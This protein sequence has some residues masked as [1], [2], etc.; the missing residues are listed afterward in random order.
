[1]PRGPPAIEKPQL[2]AKKGKKEEPKK[3]VKKHVKKQVQ[4]EIK[5]EAAHGESNKDRRKQ[6]QKQTDELFASLDKEFPVN[7]MGPEP[8]Q[9]PKTPATPTLMSSSSRPMIRNPPP[10]NAVVAGT[11]A[12]NTAPTACRSAPSPPFP[13]PAP[14]AP[15]PAPAAAGQRDDEK[16]WDE[17]RWDDKRW[18]DQRWDDKRWDD[19][20]WDDKR[21]D[22]RRWNGQTWKRSRVQ[23][24][25]W[26]EEFERKQ[27][28]MD[29]VLA[30]ALAREDAAAKMA[31]QER[32]AAE[33]HACMSQQAA[34]R[35]EVAAQRAQQERLAAEA[36]ACVS[37]QA[38]VQAARCLAWTQQCATVSREHEQQQQQ[39]SDAPKMQQQSKSAPKSAGNWKHKNKPQPKN[40]HTNPGQN[41]RDGRR[42]KEIMQKNESL[43]A[44]C[45]EAEG[46]A[47]EAEA[48]NK[49]S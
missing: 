18:D 45:K 1:M 9:G 36:H 37:K 8:K 38:A 5:P 4:P 43:K 3:Q 21:W 40:C 22:N 41:M 29:E 25:R 19:K 11:A 49:E 7:Q 35:E 34:M 17:Q 47:A 30:K 14:I 39:Q 2:E 48:K 42:F 10:F 23:D 12:S 33:A 27:K 46:R 13:Q 15:A 44:A 6:V 31:Q 32:L 20:R 26:K 28:E 24:W 16:R